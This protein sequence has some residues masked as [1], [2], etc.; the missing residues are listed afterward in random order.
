MTPATAESAPP[1]LTDLVP[2]PRAWHGPRLAREHYLVPF[3]D[4]VLAEMDAVRAELRAAP[5]PTLLLLP[6]HFALDAT[7]RFMDDVRRRLLEGTGFVVLDRLPLDRMTREEAVDLYW[8]LANFLE[9]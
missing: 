1:M 8:I 9:L 3:P 5:V 7:R 4:E 6:E 2:E